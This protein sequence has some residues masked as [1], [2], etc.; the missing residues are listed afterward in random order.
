M[1]LFAPSYERLSGFVRSRLS[2]TPTANL[3]VPFQ[4]IAEI[5]KLHPKPRFVV[6]LAPVKRS[7]W[8]EQQYECIVTGFHML[9]AQ[10]DLQIAAILISEAIGGHNLTAA[11]IRSYQKQLGND[12]YEIVVGGVNVQRDQIELSPYQVGTGTSAGSRLRA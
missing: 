5:N 6:I 10:I 7:H 11:T 1:Q 3:H 12:H 8:T 4:P 2:E 9:L